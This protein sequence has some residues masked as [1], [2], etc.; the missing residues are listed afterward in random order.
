[1]SIGRRLRETAP[2]VGGPTATSAMFTER[3]ST[4]DQHRVNDPLAKLKQRAH[5]ALFARLGQRLFDSSL[6]EQQL[7]TYV[8]QELDAVLEGELNE[9]TTD[10][11]HQLVQ[12]VSAD[13]LGLGPIEVFMADPTV[14]EVMV[15]GDDSIY[16][17]RG[18]RLYL[19]ESRFTSVEHLRQVIERIVSAVGRRI[20]ESSPLVDAR[21]PDGSRVNAVIPPLAVDGPQLT[22]RKF[23]RHGFSASDLVA[24]G[25]LSE[26]SSDFLDACVRGKRNIL[27]SGG[28]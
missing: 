2:L 1:M 22:I 4:S 5:E 15:N 7:H 21:L 3:P 25:S 17:E 20:D 27:I 19:T 6:D 14:T 13:I 18:G 11:R 16:V 12:A 9:L 28:T 24:M 10:E 23:A 26:L 8:V